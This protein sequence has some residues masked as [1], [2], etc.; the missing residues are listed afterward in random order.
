MAATGFDKPRSYSGDY[1]DDGLKAQKFVMDY[2]VK[3]PDVIG[4]EDLSQL[5]VMQEADVDCSIRTRDGLVV[6]AEIKSDNYIGKS[7][8]ILFEALRINHTCDP[9]YSMVLGW[10]ARTPAQ[11]IVYYSPDLHKI[12]II[13]ARNLRNAMQRYTN[14]ARKNGGIH[15]NVVNTDIIKSTVNI[16]IPEKYCV[17][18]VFDLKAAP[19]KYVLTAADFEELPF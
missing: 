2:L 3:R 9:A 5:K 13:S 4:V 1:M 16:L 8:N 12:W 17:F 7:G 19:E 11:F 10:S 14:D 6:L 15:P 18:E